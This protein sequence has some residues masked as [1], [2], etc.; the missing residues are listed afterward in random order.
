MTRY[1]NRNH[2]I[3]MLI[4]V[5]KVMMILSGLIL[6][7]RALKRRH[8]RPVTLVNL[9]SY[10]LLCFVSKRVTSMI[11]VLNQ[12]PFRLVRTHPVFCMPYLTLAI[13]RITLT[14]LKVVT[15]AKASPCSSYAALSSDKIRPSVSSKCGWSTN[16]Q[17]PPQ[18]RPSDSPIFPTLS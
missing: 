12:T 4:F 2:V 1:A 16:F 3:P 7:F 18:V 10:C 8:L 9:L 15:H 17:E 11:P 13:R 6:T 14:P 5:T